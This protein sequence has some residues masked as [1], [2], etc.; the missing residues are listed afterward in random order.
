LGSFTPRP[1]LAPHLL[2]ELL[3]V[4]LAALAVA[5]LGSRADAYP[6]D[7]YFYLAK[8]RSLAS[9]HLLH[10]NWGDGIDRRFFWG[11]CLALAPFIRLFG[12]AS[13]WLLAAL[14]HALTGLLL[15]R[16]FR[17]LPLEVSARIGALALA[18]FSPAALWWA[19]VPMA[20]PLLLALAAGAVLFALRYRAGSS[21]SALLFAAALSGAALL[22][23][24][25]GL[26]VAAG[27][28][29]L[30]GP[31]LLREGRRA[32]SLAFVG[33]A[34]GPELAHLV[35][36]ALHAFPVLSFGAQLDAFSGPAS[37]RPLLDSFFILLSAPF[38]PSLVFDSE[39]WRFTRYFPPW[40]TAL[41]GLVLALYALAVVGALSTGFFRRSFAFAGAAALCGYALLHALLLQTHERFGYAAA[42]LAAA[43][44]AWAAQWAFSWARESVRASAVLA[45]CFGAATTSGVCG[46][47][48]SQMNAARLRADQ[49]G[50]DLKAVARAVNQAVP[51]GHTV[52][53]DL[54][55][56]LAYHLTSH[57]FFDRSSPNL[58]DDQVPPGDAAR[59]FFA[60]HRVGAIVSSR[61]SGDLAA[62]FALAPDE[63]RELSA[64][65][66]T[67]LVVEPEA[68]NAAGP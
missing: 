26:F 67:L 13:F 43:L 25:E 20:E 66:A 24:I 56:P 48:A 1:L 37:E 33:L 64:P 19:T 52:V 16:I 23:R 8:A 22:T 68:M 46:V 49:G 57:A 12:D 58:Y 38:W 55:P 40:L 5:L 29:A 10:V 3:L 62:A 32:L 41:Q 34:L 15:A 53:T 4:G 11:Y 50:R 36:L 7:S 14:L 17:M 35:Y 18:L 30:C 31:R 45:V 54:G 60:R 44:F 21:A 65:G 2:A 61:A 6:I 63:F 39:P 51:P 28:G 59:V 42:P 47:R 27:V 9:G